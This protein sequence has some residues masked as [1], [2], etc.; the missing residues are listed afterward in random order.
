MQKIDIVNDKKNIFNTAVFKYMVNTKHF[1]Q[2]QN[3]INCEDIVLKY[4]NAS[5]K[6]FHFNIN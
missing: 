2:Y 4:K 5:A 1:Y 3:L 6:I